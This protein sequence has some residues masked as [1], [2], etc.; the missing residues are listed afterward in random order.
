MD[1]KPN[2][3]APALL[4]FNECGLVVPWLAVFSVAENFTQ[5]F[6]EDKPARRIS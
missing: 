1:T 3:S 6:L 2:Q 4:V 5:M